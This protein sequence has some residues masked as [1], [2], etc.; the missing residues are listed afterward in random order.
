MQKKILIITPRFP[1]PVLGA[2]EQDR[3]AGIRQLKA[4]G[5]EVKVIAK[6]FSFQQREEIS[7]FAESEGI[8]VHLLDYK[9]EKAHSILK[10]PLFYVK[11]FFNPLYWDGA[12]YEYSH[13]ETKKA[14]EEIAGD[15][16]PDFAWFDYTYLWPL[17]SIFQ[18]RKIPIITRS[19]NFEP[20]HFIQ[21]DGYTVINCIKFLAK[22]ASEI[23]TVKKSN[24]ILAITPKE[25]AVYRTL[26]A[27]NV[28][29]LPLR[30]LSKLLRGKREIVDK[31]TLDVFFAGSTYNVRHNQKALA[32][33]LR[34]IVPAIQKMAP[35][36]FHF[37]VI[38]SKLPEDLKIY[39]KGNVTYHGRVED[40]ESFLT[41]MDIAIVPSLF[42][43][44]MQQ[45]I[46]EPLCRG[47]PTIASR[48][49]IA[50][51]PFKH[52]E[53]LLIAETLDQF[54][55]LMLTLRD[56]DRRR[57]L[58]DNAI[59]LSEKLFSASVL[60]AA[61]LSAIDSVRIG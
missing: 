28:E 36:A 58:S 12:A 39:F 20:A 57:N 49:G 55:N 6:V 22:L 46:F 53:H 18:K 15:W 23:I 34:E 41:K 31:G 25:E 9:S 38:G 26:G 48:R 54:P 45:K 42:G 19:L 24:A 2:C 51:Y 10:H 14:V 1:L 8:A 4:L 33:I 30:G 59:A 50:G 11:R 43:A 5:F 16:R 3:L 29:T 17:Y 7:N 61:V 21:E 40:L 47:I 60:N 32:F 13:R 27:K 37:H 56:V 52:N 44:G 35:H